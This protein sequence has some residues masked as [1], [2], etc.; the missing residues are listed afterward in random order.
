L[1]RGFIRAEVCTIEQAIAGGGFEA[2]KKAGLARVEGRGYVVA[3][4]D[5][6]LIRFSV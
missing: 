1:E 4:G 3:E 6:L 5:V 2:A